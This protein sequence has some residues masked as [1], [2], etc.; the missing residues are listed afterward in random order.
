MIF[1]GVGGF[2][3]TGTGFGNQMTGG[4]SNDT[5][6]GEGGSD[7]LNGADGDDTLNGGTGADLMVGGLGNDFYF[8]DNVGDVVE[9]LAGQGT[10]TVSSNIN[11]I[12]GV[13]IENLILTGAAV[14]GTGNATNNTITGSNIA[15]ILNG[16]DGD[17][18][19]FG[20]GGNDT[21]NGGNGNDTLN[22]GAGSDTMA[23]GAG[24]DTYIVNL[25]T[26]VLT[27]AAGQGTDTVNTS[28]T[29]TLGL[30][31]ENLVLTGGSG[32][33][34]TGNTLANV[35]TGNLG[36][37][38]LAGLSGNDTLI[39]GAGN[40]R[41]SGGA[42]T[43]TLIGGAGADTYQLV[44]AL[45]TVI[46]AVGEGT[47]LVQAYF[48]YTLGANLENLNLFG[49]ALVGTGNEL[50]NRII[51]TSGNNT[52]SGMAGNDYIYGGAGNDSISG[53]A[54]R[55][56]LYGEAGADRFVFD[57]GD[58]GGAT[59]GTADLLR[60]FSL[61]DG[62]TIDLSLVDAITGGADDAFSFIGTTAFSGTAGELRYQTSATATIV[63]G[64]M[65]GDGVADFW[66]VLT[67]VHALDVSDFWL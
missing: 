65:N 11:Y 1:T 62:D 25:L 29:W 64:D 67:G 18:N 50:N 24:N 8:V 15:N 43:D 4:A 59:S 20:N 53:G 2:T 51:G 56:F 6:N 47:D 32:V 23:G 46:E 40:D 41:L 48:D 27:E 36:P 16:G 19:L 60:D 31:F 44:D 12:L 42:G 3:G 52:L 37:N 5:L 39:G 34:G 49:S 28:I 26:D 61:V 38:I 54:G 14:T 33:N 10:D 45:D 66:I 58:F 22:G 7:T 9:E 17:D 35:V 57:D 63:M 30:N 55:D 21:L 13:T